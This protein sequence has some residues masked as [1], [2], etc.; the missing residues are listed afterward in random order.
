MEPLLPIIMLIGGGI[1]IAS[2]LAG[3]SRW[4]EIAAE[5]GLEYSGG[6]QRTISGAINGF[7]IKIK[8]QKHG[9]DIRLSGNGA[10][11]SSLR[12]NSEGFL[13]TIFDGRDIEIGCP[14]FD[15]RT[16]ILSGGRNPA[17][18]VAALLDHKTREVVS[19]VVVSGGAKVSRG[20]ITLVTKTS[21]GNVVPEIHDLVR[22]A[23]HL[24]MEKSEIPGRLAANAL[25]DPVSSVQLRNLTLL[26]QRHR[27]SPEATRTSNALLESPKQAIR[28]AAAM[29]LGREGHTVVRSISLSENAETDLRVKAIRHLSNEADRE[30]II[31][32]ATAL[33]EDKSDMIQRMAVQS[34]GRVR[35]RPALDSLVALLRTEDVATSLEIV[36]A[37][38]RIGDPSAE[39]ALIELLGRDSNRVK[40]AVIE[41]LGR[42][43]TVRAVEPLY[44][45]TKR[46]R[47]KRSARVAIDSIQSRLGDVE[48]GRLSLAPT[49]DPDGALSLAGDPEKAG[50]LSLDEEGDRPSS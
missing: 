37:I 14:S 17:A 40:T 33:L 27:D 50:G 20:D 41:A 46:M 31:E 16:Q 22:L 15:A 25:H 13:S 34:L 19:R 32:I 35:H 47:F 12:L 49:I 1:A 39:T 36:K 30:D 42:L 9:V 38:E 21:I 26:Q 4:K 23:R 28:L 43:G 45:F 6:F 24:K 3:G 7:P 8:Q 5:L 11:S 2:A 18:E 44:E 29:F 10:F 48:S